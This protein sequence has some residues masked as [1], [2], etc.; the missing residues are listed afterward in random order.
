[1]MSV[2]RVMGRGDEGAERPFHTGIWNFV[3]AVHG[4]GMVQK[5]ID[6]KRK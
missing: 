4:M 3:Y 2:N 5:Y 6:A 1:M